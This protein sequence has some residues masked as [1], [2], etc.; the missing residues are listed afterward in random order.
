MPGAH[1]LKWWQKGVFYQIYPRSFADGIGDGM[2]DFHGMIHRLDY[3]EAVGIDAVWL[4]PHY[5]SPFIDC[6]YDVA[7]YAD[8]APDI[9]GIDPFCSAFA[10]QTADMRLMPSNRGQL[11]RSGQLL[12]IRRAVG[13]RDRDC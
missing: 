8:V 9:R 10:L 11:L 2:G 1:E 6:G 4:S 12:V 13:R 3:L 5:P 7:D